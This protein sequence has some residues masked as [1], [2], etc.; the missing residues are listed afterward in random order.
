MF[1]TIAEI[2]RTSHPLPVLRVRP[3][4]RPWLKALL[5]ATIA[6]VFGA[7]VWLSLF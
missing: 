1:Q 6:A 7:L 5:A 4:A 2:F 3:L